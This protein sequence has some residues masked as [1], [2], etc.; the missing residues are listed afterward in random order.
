VS[1]ASGDSASK[2]LPQVADPFRHIAVNKR[3]RHRAIL[4]LVQSQLISS[5]EE[6][7]GLLRELGWDVTQSTLSRDLRELR[8]ARIPTPEGPR[9]ASSE[10]FAGNDNRASVEDVLPQFFAAAEGVGELVVLKTMAGGAQPV[11]E[12]ID[13]AG[14]PEVIGTIAGENA[15]LI[16]CRSAAA[17]ERVEKKIQR[18]A[19]T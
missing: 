13:A 1:I 12:A 9:Y 8:L 7:R 2:L 17:R 10:T 14:W 19:H 18:V 16:I 11:A 6:L 5:Q 3:Q 15:I 4:D